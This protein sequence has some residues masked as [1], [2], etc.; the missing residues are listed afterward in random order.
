MICVML[1]LLGYL[2]IAWLG[3]GWSRLWSTAPSVTLHLPLLPLYVSGLLCGACSE[4]RSTTSIRAE[5]FPAENNPH[6][7]FAETFLGQ[8]TCSYGDLPGYWAH[9]ANSTVGTWT[10]LNNECQLQVSTQLL[11][12]ISHL[13]LYATSLLHHWWG[14]GLWIMRLGLRICCGSAGTQRAE[15]A[16]R[17]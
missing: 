9:K 7:P 5:S 10:L 16:C 14:M 2:F 8:T 6:V 4:G 13:T 1:C 11:P 12:V 3:G 15:P 17:I